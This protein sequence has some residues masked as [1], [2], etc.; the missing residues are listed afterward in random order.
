M[1]TRAVGDLPRILHVGPT[2]PVPEA[3]IAA[4]LRG[5]LASP[6]ATRFAMQAL[7]TSVPP[8]VRRH[9]ALR[10]FLTLG[11][12]ARL[13]AALARVQPDLVH[14]HTS[15]YAG[16]WE[17]GLFAARATRRGRPV[18]LHLHGGSFDRF[19]AALSPRQAERARRIFARAARIVVLSHAWR[20]L[21][22]RFAP[23]DKLVVLP[24]AID[25]AEFEAAATRAP[26]T[27]PRILFLGQISARKGLDELQAAL[28]Q[29]RAAG[30]RFEVE[31]AGGEEFHGERVRTEARF[32]AAG[33]ADVVQFVGPVYGEAKLAALQRADL[34]CLP[35]R[36][37]SFGIANLEAMAAGLPVVSTRTGAIPET[38][39]DGVHGLLV[40]PGDAAGLAAALGRLLGDP[41]LRA[42]LGRAARERA[43]DFDWTVVATQVATVY[44]DV[45]AHR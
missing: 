7:D 17:K 31:I 36:H 14:V 5:L 28:L 16:F 44:D 37:E 12:A 35:S 45:L 22:A 13:E 21:V 3:G 19:L 33:L 26:H 11:F 34:F 40:D 18:V 41:S 38:I 30:V 9:R 1:E 20:P 4:Y 39:A 2:P 10:P 29:L 32:A 8:V 15:D 25:C 27:V 43:Q 24:N 23:D 6:L 42:A